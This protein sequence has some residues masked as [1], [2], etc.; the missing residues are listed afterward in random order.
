MFAAT[1]LAGP[2]P[3][4]SIDTCPSVVQLGAAATFGGSGT[5]TDGQN[6]TGFSWSFGD[7]SGSSDQNPSH[8]YASPGNYPVS[9]TVSDDTPATSAPATCSVKVNNPP[10]AGFNWSQSTANVSPAVQF[11]ASASDSD[12]SISS[13]SWSFGD[14][15]NGSGA[16]TSHTYASGGDHT[17]TLTVTDNNGG[18]TQVQHTV[19]T[20]NAPTAAITSCPAVAQLNGPAVSFSGSGTPFDGASIQSLDWT[21]GDGGTGS[22]ANPSHAFTSPGN[23]H[24]GLTAT[25][26]TGL[27]GPQAPQN[28]SVRVNPPPKINVK[29]SFAVSSALTGQQ[30]Q[31]P[32]VGQ[33]LAI[34]GINAT[35]TTDGTTD[36]KNALQYAWAIDNGVQVSS[37]R[38]WVSQPLNQP[39][40][41]TLAVQVTDPDGAKGTDSTVFRVDEPPVA[42]FIHS[43]VTPITSDTIT[44]TSTSD[45][46]DL[47]RLLTPDL[48]ESLTYAWDLN[49]D[50]KFDDGNGPVATRQFTTAGTHNVALKVTDAAGISAVK[51]IAVDVQTSRP[52]GQFTWA[53][54]APVPGQD[55]TFTSNSTPSD[56]SK[57]ISNTEWDFNFDGSNFTPDATGTTVTHSFA[58]PGPHSVALRVTEHKDGTTDGVGIVTDTVRVNAPPS[59]VFAFN[60]AEPAAGEEVTL[61]SASFDPDGPLARQDWDLNGDGQFDDASAA[62]V[63]VRFLQPGTYPVSLRVTDTDGATSTVTN[64]ITVHPAAVTPA[65]GTTA[66]AVV[67]TR[68][69]SASVNIAGTLKGRQTI[70]NRIYVMA[71]KGATVAMQCTQPREAKSQKTGK[72]VAD[73]GIKLKKLVSHGSR[74]RLRQLERSFPAKTHI[75]VTV[76]QPGFVSRVTSFTMRAGRQPLREELCQPAGTKK[77]TRCVA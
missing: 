76:S 15:T 66:I 3:V 39:G 24:V 8:T 64:N 50:G 32:K 61:S 48:A 47:H 4:A 30:A 14:G 22:G 63:T 7:G 13:F 72:A 40:L 1:V 18:T 23:R 58:T 73:C 20:H 34:S 28:C 25:D 75:T 11:S 67:G 77:P 21:F 12:G 42:D 33:S 65:P 46:P 68:L 9:L 19:H 55:V 35:D 38:D 17:V 10:S 26:D 43:P 2:A 71:P 41:H 5:P 56:P 74:M 16:N 37:A 54:N 57:T 53:P 44:F 52:N 27:T 69:V 45:D 60:P 6:L 62:V 70:V 59:A 49:G 31:I 51:Q 29:N 36:D